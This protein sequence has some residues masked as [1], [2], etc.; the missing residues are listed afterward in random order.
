M[1]KH[2]YV[3]IYRSGSASTRWP[4]GART[5]PLSSGEAT[6]CTKRS[7]GNC[8][9]KLIHNSLLPHTLCPYPLIISMVRQA[10]Q[11]TQPRR[12]CSHGGAVSSNLYREFNPM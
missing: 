2:I 1:Y 6:A 7:R 5:R 3:C 4:S 11:E 9:Q 12:G 10:S 8:Q